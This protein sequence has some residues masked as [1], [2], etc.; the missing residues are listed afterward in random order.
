MKPVI[1]FDLDGTLIDSTDAILQG[2][3]AAFLAHDKALVD[4]DF[5]KSLIGHTLEDIFL[6][7]GVSEP[8]LSSY[9]DAYKRHYTQIYLTKT[10]LLEGA[11]EAVLMAHGFARLGVV[12]TKSSALLPELLNHLGILKYF[13]VLIGRNDVLNPKPNP[14]PINLA[15]SRL[16]FSQRENA[17]MVG[18]TPLDILAAKAAEVNPVGVLCGYSDFYTLSKF[19]AK[20]FDTSLDAVKFICLKVLG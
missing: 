16:G 12:T 15:L 11:F 13:E 17:F 3:N 9:I 18:D 2:F 20:I 1:L 4:E 6:K 7:L 8:E 10:S 5:A 19:D 14:E